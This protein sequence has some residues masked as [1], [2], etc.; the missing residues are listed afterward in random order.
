M[1]WTHHRVV[2]REGYDGEDEYA[3][4]DCLSTRPFHFR[5]HVVTVL[6]APYIVSL[7]LSYRIWFRTAS[8]FIFHQL[9]EV[10]RHKI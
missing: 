10:L 1:D 6:R 9:A 8:N 2:D 4:E 7:V 3:C 5:Q